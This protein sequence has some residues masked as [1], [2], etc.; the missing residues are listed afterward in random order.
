MPIVLIDNYDSFTFNLYQML[1]TRT[2]ESVAVYRNDK[3]ELSELLALKPSRLV[4][5]PG[6]GH[7]ANDKDFGV[8]KN[9]ILNQTLLNCPILGVCLG[10]Q[11]IVHHLGGQVVGAP[12]IVHGK[13]SYV[14]IDSPS[15]LLDG[16]PDNFEAMRY[17]SLVAAE[18]NFPQELVVTAREAAH[19]L[20]MALAHR[21]KPIYGVQFHP[22][23]IGTPEGGKILQNFISKC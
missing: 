16:L 7:P 19:G 12:Q 1:Q 22:E 21:S 3:I 14:R 6:P 2:A 23:S 8:C 17:H 18:E 20:I 4:L 9:I 13:S 5:S 11:G 10:H 15:P